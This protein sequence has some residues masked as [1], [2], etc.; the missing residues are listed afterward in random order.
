MSSTEPAPL[1][2]SKHLELPVPDLLAR[3]RPFPPSREMS[4]D[5][6]SEDEGVAFLADLG[7]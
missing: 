2:P 6:I 7:A 1:G 5:D 3:A 4:I